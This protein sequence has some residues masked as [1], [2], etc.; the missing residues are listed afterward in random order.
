MNQAIEDTE[1]EAGAEDQELRAM[2]DEAER[3]ADK[4]AAM[5]EEADREAA[6]DEE[7]FGLLQE[8]Q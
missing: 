1:F 2:R 6:M 5:Q 4:E 8:V 3:E 7:A